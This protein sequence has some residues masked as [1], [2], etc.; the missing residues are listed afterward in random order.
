MMGSGK[1][2][3]AKKLAELTGACFVDLD[4]LISKRCGSPVR[5][6]FASQGEPF[7]RDQE[8]AMLAE[9]ARGSGQ[10][11][12][13]GGGIILRPENVELMRKTGVV[14]YLDTSLGELWRRVKDKKDRPLLLG[15]DPRGRLAG[16]LDSRAALYEAS[17][18]FKVN[19]NG[20]L[21]FDVALEIQAKIGKKI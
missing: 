2:V 19:T 9:I 15:D 12:A 8:S 18:N 14:V 6:I 4:E 17:S 16:L 1:S 11:V 10:V 20:R 5:E 21:A 7:F 3:T 13:T